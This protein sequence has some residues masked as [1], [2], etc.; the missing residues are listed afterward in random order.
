MKLIIVGAGASGKDFL[1][2]KLIS[3]GFSP[4]TSYTTRPPRPG[5]IDGEDYVF[6][7]DAT[8]L[9]M[10]AEDKFR[11]W[12][13]FTEKGWYYGTTNDHFKSASLFVMTPSGIRALT[14]DERK[15]F[16]VIYLDI[17]ESVR[18]ERLLSRRDADFADRRLK[19]DREDFEDFE[20]FDIRITNSDF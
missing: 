20:D 19:T 1:K 14:P 7:D 11:E 2:K 17:P 8:F 18:R 4:S 16:F 10:V 15:E 5:E 6:V 9:S 12:N 3:K 13:K